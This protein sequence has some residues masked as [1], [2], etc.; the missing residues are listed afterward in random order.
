MLIILEALGLAISAPLACLWVAF[1]MDNLIHLPMWTRTLLLLG[2]L[3]GTAYLAWS[4][5]KRWRSV[6]LTEDQVA[7]AMERQSGG[8]SN[9]IINSVQ[10]ARGEGSSLRFSQDVIEENIQHLR[11]LQVQQAA[12]MKPAVVR[13]GIAFSLVA[14]G[15]FF[16][17]ISPRHFTNAAQRIF[18]PIVNIEPIYRTYVSVEPGNVTAAQ[19]TDVL[20]R[21]TISG[22]IPD[23]IQVVQILKNTRTSQS[24]K[25][26]KE[27]KNVY[28]NFSNLQE[29]V[30]YVVM[31]NDYTSGMFKIDV[32]TPGQIMGMKVEF[33]YPAYT[34]MPRKTIDT[35]AGEL[36]AIDGTTGKIRFTLDR[37]VENA[38][39]VV[40][41]ESPEQ[42]T[43]AARTPLQRISE[44]EFSGQVE[45][46]KTQKFRIEGQQK[47]DKPF[48]T[49][50]YALRGT[51][52][53]APLVELTGLGQQS[54]VLQ[55]S[56]L[57]VKIAATDDIG[58]AKVGLFFT[59][60]KSASV[61]K[62][63][64]Q[65][66][67]TELDPSQDNGWT[68]IEVWTVTDNDKQL[69]KD[70]KIDIRSLGAA[71]GDQLI[72]VLRAQDNNP[73][74]AGMWA[75]EQPVAVVVGSE[76]SSFQLLYEQILQSQREIKD[77]IA[78]QNALAQATAKW[79][80][81]VDAGTDVRWDD[82][83]VREK[84]MATAQQNA[85]EQN[86]IRELGG[87]VARSVIEQAQTVRLSIAMIVDTEMVQT[88]RMFEGV[89]QREHGQAIR[90]AIADARNVQERTLKGLAQVED[91]FSKFRQ[92]WEY[93]NMASFVKMLATRQLAMREESVAA[94]A[95]DAARLAEGNRKSTY[96]RQQKMIQLVALAQPAFVALAQRTAE[97]GGDQAEQ[98]KMMAE[99]FKTAAADLD[100]SALKDAM[101]QAAE[102]ASAGDFA[103]VAHLQGEAGTQLMGVY[104]KLKAV[105]DAIALKRT[106]IAKQEESK[107][108]EQGE[109]AQLE[110]GITDNL[111][112]TDPDQKL[113][114][115]NYSR[116]ATESN[117]KQKAPPPSVDAYDFD[118]LNTDE[119]LNPGKQHYYQT[120]DKLKLSDKA[121]HDMSFPNSNNTKANKVTP[122]IQKD[123]DDVMGAL[124][125]M[126]DITRENYESYR[127]QYAG[128][129]DEGGDIAP[130]GGD[131]SSTSA[132]A[133]TGNQKQPPNN[134]GGASRSGR[135]G[136]RAFGQNVDDTTK[137]AKGRDETL[138]GD[139]FTTRVAGSLKE[140]DG[141]PDEP[142]TGY[143]GKHIDSDNTMFSAKDSGQF[144]DE[145]ISGMGKVQETKKIVERDSKTGGKFN[146]ALLSKMYDLTSNT[147]Q[148]IERVKTIKK[149]FNT[150]YLPTSELDEI[151]DQ[152]K[153]TLDKMKD[154]PDPELFRLQVKNLDRL[155]AMAKVMGQA[156]S[157][158]QPSLP[159]KQTVRGRVLDEP[160]ASVV[161]GYED[162][163]GAYFKELSENR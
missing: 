87:Q 32:P 70:Y 113:T 80:A 12:R 81:E 15:V 122:Q 13:V 140:G 66:K 144:R 45:F 16:Y 61:Q 95:P 101:R 55:E 26:D 148:V 84:V 39:L 21:F 82:E 3:G 103:K 134:S 38:T 43:R 163:V 119:A 8:L 138:D 154:N 106:E 19:G 131:L 58:L 1:L 83:K 128:I 158:F 157:S 133:A 64:L 59:K 146:A 108:K 23:E 136:G 107:A 79:I 90:A 160:P 149:D 116:E 145:A 120:A 30:S 109:V 48:K 65:A 62:D 33:D 100:A 112:D 37:P 104:A 31:A 97:I 50:D 47:G 78:R 115:S 52:D 151:T 137:N 152:L 142:S 96:A 118:A 88:I 14:A 7:L 25:V 89:P 28:F 159:R 130:Q 123:F 20:A 36:Q 46:N 44:T 54:S 17:V 161:P 124:V 18:M 129:V 53:N 111:L 2:F 143:G 72:I 121:M 75:Y 29:P 147:E 91:D 51:S 9:R 5:V 22:T 155:M 49:A 92:E 156:Q 86:A 24:L 150:L 76:G 117:G 57:P 67:K 102:L 125:D 68:P 77:L 74:R 98:H 126:A 35:G 27:K 141:K 42:A 110:K 93:R 41:S 56:Q 60:G 114:H 73:A 127:T 162:A 10:L 69:Q 6:H 4:L 99:A 105:Q 94:Q 139:E 135:T 71:E 63:G 40:E 132:T 85:K 11:N 34:R 153:I